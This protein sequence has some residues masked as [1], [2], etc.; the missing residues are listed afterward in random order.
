ML[1]VIACRRAMPSPKRAIVPGA[2]FSTATSTLA[3]SS[4]ARAS[5]SGALRSTHTLFFPAHVK[6]NIAPYPLT[7]RTCRAS[8]P[9]SGAILITSAPRS[10]NI[11]VHVGP[12]R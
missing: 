9:C 5:P 1:G 12:A 3:M 10:A 8:S 11:L 2:K 6:A 4:V 7:C